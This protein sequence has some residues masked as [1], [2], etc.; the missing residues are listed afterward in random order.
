M[1][2]CKGDKIRDSVLVKFSEVENGQRKGYDQ[3]L[4]K[5]NT[6]DIANYTKYT[7]V[8]FIIFLFLLALSYC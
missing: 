5:N 4:L 3:E 1:K 2:Q 6:K 8:Y 7:L